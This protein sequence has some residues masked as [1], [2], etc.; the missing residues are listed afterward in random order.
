MNTHIEH[1]LDTVCRQIKCKTTHN[2]I[3]EE[4]TE[5]IEEL[6]E[7]YIA[8][9]NDEATA[10]ERALTQM[11]DPQ[12]IGR[13]LHKTHKPQTDW[14]TLGLLALLLTFGAFVLSGYQTYLPFN[15]GTRQT[16]FT[17]IGLCIAA[18]FYFTD[19]TK[20][21]KYSLIL[22]GV[23]V[24]F[25]LYMLSTHF[26]MGGFWLSIGSVAIDSSAL[27]LCGYML[28]LSG[29][30]IHWQTERPSDSWFLI[31]AMAL[32]VILISLQHLAKAFI[33]I[34]ICLS[35]LH[36]S[37]SHAAWCTNPKKQLTILYSILA[38]LFLAS[39][40]LF[41]ASE[42]YRAARFSAFLHPE[43]DPMGSGY[44]AM[45][46]RT[47]MANTPWFQGMPQKDAFFETD[48]GPRF[49]V[50]EAHTD[51][52]FT[53]IIGRFGWGVAIALCFIMAVLICKMIQ[54]SR[55]IQDSYGKALCY[56]ITGFFAAQI[57]CNILMNLTLFPYS[58]ISLPFIS[59]G[60]SMLVLDI[61]LMAI[62]LNVYRR[63]NLVAAPAIQ[64]TIGKKLLP[65][66][67]IK[68]TWK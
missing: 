9:G 43:N 23:S 25:N 62:F 17:A 8:Q 31:S 11:G 33:L 19:Y 51:L 50:P 68:V 28:S 52:V 64:G 30:A 32:A 39:S 67:D 63:K 44:V 29:L 34:I 13:Q 5:H 66:I 21:F 57:I 41:I 61:V 55:K 16:F 49:I 60:G 1:Y 45:Q 46:Q 37:I 18:L 24:I 40:F 59:Y 56:S 47:V 10:T 48:Y 12:E 42:P 54:L 53:Y 26:N 22:Y 14:V 35:L 15:I 38:V 27:I 3:R 7:A 36:Y 2:A 58:S 6:Q 65:H 4:L 20:L